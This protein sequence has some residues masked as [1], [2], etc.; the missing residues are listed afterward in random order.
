MI[1]DLSLLRSLKSITFE[2]GER[3]NVKISGSYAHLAE[4]FVRACWCVK[5]RGLRLFCY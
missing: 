4:A 2:Y 1:S 3:G 5:D